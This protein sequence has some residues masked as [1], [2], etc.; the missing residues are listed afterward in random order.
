MLGCQLVE[1]LARMGTV[2]CG[3]DLDSCWQHV[4]A[5][6]SEPRTAWVTKS[7]RCT[8]LDKTSS[9][10]WLIA[11]WIPAPCS[12]LVH[13]FRGVTRMRGKPIDCRA[14]KTLGMKGRGRWRC[15]T[16]GVSIHHGGGSRFP[17]S[18]FQASVFSS[19]CPTPLWGITS[20][21]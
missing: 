5:G 18:F 3:F 6:L 4:H 2:L 21:E 17:W 11:M 14:E 16:G 9:P 19:R 13:S 10:V 8:T 1:S 12:R 20:P 15:A 7:A